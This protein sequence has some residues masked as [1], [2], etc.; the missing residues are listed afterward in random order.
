M[1][2]RDGQK[3][4]EE[5]SV[6][7]MNRSNI[8]LCLVYYRSLRENIRETI[9]IH[10]PLLSFYPSLRAPRGL[11]PEHT[12]PY[13]QANQRSIDPHTTREISLAPQKENVIAKSDAI[14]DGSQDLERKK[15]SEGK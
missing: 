1:Q 6:H 14:R 9:N 12:Y 5:K 8:N 15:R 13:V 4:R 11:S 7:V 10:T 2:W 3:R